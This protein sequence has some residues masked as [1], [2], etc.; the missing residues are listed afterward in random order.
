MHEIERMYEISQ[1]KHDAALGNG[2]GV[3]GLR[4][5]IGEVM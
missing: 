2:G 1:E 4:L 5:R 3:A